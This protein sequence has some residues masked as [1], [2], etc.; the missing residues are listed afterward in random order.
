MYVS[1]HSGDPGPWGTENE[2]PGIV[3]EKLSFDENGFTRFKILD[4]MRAEDIRYI[5][6]WAKRL[7]GDYL[8]GTKCIQTEIVPGLLRPG[9]SLN[10]NIPLLNPN[11]RSA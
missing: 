3:R 1:L 5:A 10:L 2:I 4:A 8:T 6:L 7:H 9:D 11:L